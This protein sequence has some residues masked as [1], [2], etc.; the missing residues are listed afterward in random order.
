M[1]RPTGTGSR[2]DRTAEGDNDAAMW[3]LLLSLGGPTC[4]TGWRYVLLRL[5]PVM[6]AQL[7]KVQSSWKR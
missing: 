1:R 7:A 4:P 5:G 6:S 3:P 2:P